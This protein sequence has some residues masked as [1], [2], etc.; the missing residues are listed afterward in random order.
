M[1]TVSGYSGPRV[2]VFTT[3]DDGWRTAFDLREA[4]VPPVA[5]IDARR[6]YLPDSLPKRSVS[7]R[8]FCSARECD[9]CPRDRR[10]RN[11]PRARPNWPTRQQNVDCRH[12]RSL[13]RLESER[14]CSPL[15]LGGRPRWS[16]DHQRVCTGDLTDGIRVAGAAAGL[17]YSGGCSSQRHHG[18]RQRLRGFRIHT[19]EISS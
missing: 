8:R 1:S 9:R 4:G 5:I 18:R 7:M 10:T 3:S 15:H 16:A 19:W 12:T 2:A 6:R 11:D 13:G 17:F 14:R